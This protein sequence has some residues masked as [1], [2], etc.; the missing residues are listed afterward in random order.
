MFPISV[1]KLLSE[2]IFVGWFPLV[3]PSDFGF[4]KV[5]YVH[6]EWLSELNFFGGWVYHFNKTLKVYVL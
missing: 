1:V 6:F 4:A 2:V 3:F 5:S